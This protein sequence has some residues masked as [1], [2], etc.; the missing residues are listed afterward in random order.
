LIPKANE[1][2]DL[3]LTITNLLHRQ[4]YGYVPAEFKKALVSVRL[5]RKDKGSDFYIITILPTP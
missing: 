1:R 2:W 4:N 3:T 5:L